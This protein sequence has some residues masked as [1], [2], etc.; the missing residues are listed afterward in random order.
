MLPHRT[1]TRSFVFAQ[2]I[3]PWLCRYEQ[4]LTALMRA[5]RQRSCDAVSRVARRLMRTALDAA[6]H[7]LSADELAR[8]AN[9]LSATS[10]RVKVRAIAH[11]RAC[12]L[13]AQPFAPLRRA[14]VFA[15]DE[16]FRMRFR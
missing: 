8:L 1:A 11:A 7:H 12:P 14:V 6:V 2:W 4:R 5:V 9:T 3:E 10:N 15:S 13:C 16:T